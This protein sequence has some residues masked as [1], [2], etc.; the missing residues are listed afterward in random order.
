M[1][2][3]SSLYESSRESGILVEAVY[4]DHRRKPFPSR[5]AE[6]I[7]KRYRMPALKD[8]IYWNPK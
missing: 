5:N 7:C 3:K 2:E 1:T 4:E 6:S 8:R